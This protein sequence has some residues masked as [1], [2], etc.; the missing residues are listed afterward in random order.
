M[1]YGMKLKLKVYNWGRRINR[2]GRQHR[3]G[4]YEPLRTLNGELLLIVPYG[5]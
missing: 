5:A 4:Y 1:P 2:S 3:P